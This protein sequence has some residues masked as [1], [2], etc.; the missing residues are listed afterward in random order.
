[1]TIRGVQKILREQGVRHVS[2]VADDASLDLTPADEE[3]ALAQA[4]GESADQ[5]EEAEVLPAAQAE[6]AQIIALQAALRDTPAASQ[7]EQDAP[8]QEAQ[9][10]DMWQNDGDAADTP[11]PEDDPVPVIPPPPAPK[12]SQPEPVDLFSR[13]SAPSQTAPAAAPPPAASKTAAEQPPA[14]EA[15]MAVWAEEGAGDGL[16]STV[17]DQ[18]S[19]PPAVLKITRIGPTP[20]APEAERP[21]APPPAPPAVETVTGPTLAQRLRALS[22][23]ALSADDRARL[24]ELRAQAIAVR[25]RLAGPAKARP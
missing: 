13:L 11:A 7:P 20:R 18:T 10:V 8:Q 15:P 4:L 21:S 23:T 22:V 25:A 14:E 12:V 6:T 1:M 19:T 16:D 5:A 24:L 9:I 3:A 2:G 17:P